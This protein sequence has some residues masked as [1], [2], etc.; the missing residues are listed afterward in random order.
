VVPHDCNP[1]SWEAEAGEYKFNAILVHS[2]TLSQKQKNTTT[3]KKST[4]N[5]KEIKRKKR[6]YIETVE[7]YSAIQKNEILPISP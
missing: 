4:E 1:S 7:N 2:E 5:E 6:W 3:E